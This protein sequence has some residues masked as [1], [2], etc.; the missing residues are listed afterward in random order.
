MK[1]EKGE[2]YARILRPRPLL[3]GAAGERANRD[4]RETRWNTFTGQPEGA[5]GAALASRTLPRRGYAPTPPPPSRH[6]FATA[7]RF[8]E[9]LK[10]SDQVYHA[11]CP[12]P[13]IF[14]TFRS[15]EEA[16]TQIDTSQ[17]ATK[18]F[19]RVINEGISRRFLSL[20]SL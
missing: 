15:D 20:C 7:S 14:G 10:T 6:A 9:R 16:P 3:G 19:I 17:L 1:E 18:L 4:D 12:N 13:C 5:R 11:A 8:E 2:S